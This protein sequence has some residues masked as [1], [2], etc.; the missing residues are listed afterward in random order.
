MKKVMSK[1]DLVKVLNK[2]KENEFVSRDEEKA[3]MEFLMSN[4][5]YFSVAME[6]HEM[7]LEDINRN[8]N[9]DVHILIGSSIIEGCREEV[10]KVNKVF[11]EVCD[12]NKKI[13]EDTEKLKEVHSVEKD[14]LE[15]KIEFLDKQL[16]LYT[17]ENLVS[18]KRIDVLTLDN[19]I[20]SIELEINKLL[21]LGIE[22]D[23][24]AIKTLNEKINSL[25]GKLVESE[26]LLK[27]RETEKD[28]FYANGGK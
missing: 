20:K 17:C 12:E 9:D 16:S 26:E 7:S 25:K 13:I 4:D 1:K 3:I 15:T 19:K 24:I 27:I 23:G 5:T 8:I 28:A 11:N 18:S 22:E 21:R 6:S 10:K 14:L 2:S